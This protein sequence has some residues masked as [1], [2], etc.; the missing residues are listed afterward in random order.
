MMDAAL[1]SALTGGLLIGL[2]ATCML[3]LLGRITGISGI[4]AGCLMP[5]SDGIWRFL[6]VAG[7]IAGPWL[8]HEF[9]ATPAPLPSEAGLLPTVLAG[10][11]VG[12]GTR[13]GG[14][15]TSGHGVCGI[16]RL[17]LR[18]IVSTMVFISVGVITVFITRHLLG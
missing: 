2:S 14:G 15:C 4:F 10:L 12:F 5:A 13:M 3:W 1:I 11:L 7:L 8:F 18:S 17:S 16:G 9:T 6:F